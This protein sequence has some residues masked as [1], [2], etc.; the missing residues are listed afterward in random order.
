MPH[1]QQGHWTGSQRS[2]NH[3]DRKAV[4]TSKDLEKRFEMASG[5]VI[6][7]SLA[8]K[9]SRQTLR[10]TQDFLEREEA[11]Y[12]FRGT[13]SDLATF[14]NGR[15]PPG[16]HF[17]PFFFNKP[18]GR[19]GFCFPR[20]NA[21]KILGY[22]GLPGPDNQPDHGTLRTHRRGIT[23]VGNSCVELGLKIKTTKTKA[24]HF[25]S[26]TPRSPLKLQDTNINWVNSFPY[27]GIWLDS[28][29]TFKKHVAATK[30]RA[31]SR[32]RILRIMTG[33]QEGTNY[34]VLRTF[35]VQAIRSLIDY[36]APCLSLTSATQA[37]ALET[38]QNEA[39]RIMAGESR[40]TRTNILH[41]ETNTPPIRTRL[42]ALTISHFTKFFRHA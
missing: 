26:Q 40:W 20:C 15:Q 6:L 29:L 21:P 9:G 18:G 34:D 28:Q 1:F 8:E 32:I 25:G 11:A 38:V 35:Y 14:E 12:L 13:L 42:T 16:E 41:L 5:P 39:L 31:K 2:L 23:P 4:V 17:K 19:P 24:V 7:A 22:G 36:G 3:P 37:S 33:F 27:L 30:E 10:W